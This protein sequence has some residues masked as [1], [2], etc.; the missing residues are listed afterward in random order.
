MQRSTSANRAATSVRREIRLRYGHHAVTIILR[1]G[2]HGTRRAHMKETDMTQF[3]T[4]STAAAPP[5]DQASVWAAAIAERFGGLRIDTFRRG[6]FAGT[7]THSSVGDIQ[8]CRLSAQAHRAANAPR[9][10][11]QRQ[12]SYKIAMQLAGHSEFEQ[13]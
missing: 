2:N 3:Q 9:S 1:D 12:R 5:K 7:I 11:A 10:L 6:D 8:I 4:I 13:D